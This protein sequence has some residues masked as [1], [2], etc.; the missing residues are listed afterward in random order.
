MEN[1]YVDQFELGYA[2][3]DR[4]KDKTP[5]RAPAT[6]PRPSS[7]TLDVY[8][9]AIT[10]ESVGSR[11]RL[12]TKEP[13][14]YFVPK[15]WPTCMSLFHFCAHVDIT[16]KRHVAQETAIVVKSPSLQH[17]LLEL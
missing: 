17:H 7:F 1:I 10:R 5:E 3:R 8:G 15:G 2:A 11:Y 13:R 4:I 12:T 14:L 9:F 16:H 6:L